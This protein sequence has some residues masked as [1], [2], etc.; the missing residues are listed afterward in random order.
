MPPE[1][2]LYKMPYALPM[3]TELLKSPSAGTLTYSDLLGQ[4]EQSDYQ[5]V[6][7]MLISCSTNAQCTWSCLCI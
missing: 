6:V 3:P 1:Q 4:G 2:L 5:L 7:K